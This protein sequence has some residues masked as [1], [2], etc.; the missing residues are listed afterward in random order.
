MVRQVVPQFA[1]QP[2]CILE[3]WSFVAEPFISFTNKMVQPHRQVEHI[4][5]SRMSTQVHK[6][7]C[8]VVSVRCFLTLN[9]PP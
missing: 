8:L 4:G 9:G 6:K 7:K 2:R 3:V 5:G 1:F